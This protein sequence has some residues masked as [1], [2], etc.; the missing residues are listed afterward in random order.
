MSKRRRSTRPWRCSRRVNGVWRTHSHVNVA[1]AEDCT[2]AV[3]REDTRI[4]HRDK[5]QHAA[6]YTVDGEWV[7]IKDD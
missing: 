7:G 1:Q 5:N 4:W 6:G 2:L 3:P